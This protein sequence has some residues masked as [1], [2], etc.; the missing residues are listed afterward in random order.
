M[1]H[2]LRLHSSSA[3][4]ILH[5]EFIAKKKEKK[6]T[7]NYN[8]NRKCDWFTKPAALYVV[9]GS[10]ST[11][12]SFSYHTLTQWISLHHG[13]AMS[14]A[15]P[16]VDDTTDILRYPGLFLPQQCC[17][18]STT[19]HISHKAQ[20]NTSLRRGVTGKIQSRRLDFPSL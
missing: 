2:W 7:T 19:P 9:W 20:E 4:K 13:A 11:S 5:D 1:A 14:W 16:H 15:S 8:I 3:T 10:I 17:C 6:K 18:F 12:F